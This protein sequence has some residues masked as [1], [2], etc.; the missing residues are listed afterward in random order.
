M[1]IVRASAE[2]HAAVDAKFEKGDSVRIKRP[3]SYWFQEIGTVV[4][5]AKGE[6][7]RYPY[8]VRFQKVNYAGVTTGN[9]AEDELQGTAPQTV[10]SMRARRP[11]SVR[12]SSGRAAM[13]EKI[14]AY[15]M[16]MKR[17]GAGR[18]ARPPIVRA[19]ARSYKVTLVTPEGEKTIEVPGDQYI[20]DAAE[21][22]GIDLPYSC[23]AGSCSSCCGKV[24]SGSVDQTDQAFLDDDQM[25][26]GFVLTCVAYPTS[27]CTIKTHQEDEL[28]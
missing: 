19:S 12:A 8:T 26:N 23:R 7:E 1:V 24:L 17:G 22:Q 28:I 14:Q 25:A 16:S 6:T 4:T 20:L 5:K 13:E 9:F 3:E 27:D 15:S 2:Q 10:T 21:E 18:A 11:F